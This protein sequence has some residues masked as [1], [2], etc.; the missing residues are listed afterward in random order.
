MHPCFSGQNATR[1]RRRDLRQRRPRRCRRTNRKTEDQLSTTSRRAPP[2]IHWRSRSRSRRRR[3]RQR[4]GSRPGES[5][6]SSSWLS[7]VARATSSAWHAARDDF[8]RPDAAA[9][10]TTTTK[11][12]IAQP[13]CPRSFSQRLIDDHALL[14]HNRE[15]YLDFQMQ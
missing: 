3:R 4:G 7:R 1:R 12:A 6:S 8:A 5:A 10:P 14:L 2:C 11:S 9:H 15:H 13:K